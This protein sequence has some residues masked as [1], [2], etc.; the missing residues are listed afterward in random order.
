MD[1][2]KY[3]KILSL[4]GNL[5]RTHLLHRPAAFLLR[6]AHNQR[7]VEAARAPLEYDT[8]T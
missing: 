6:K 4:A 8:W 3:R 7:G 2:T 5:G 1:G